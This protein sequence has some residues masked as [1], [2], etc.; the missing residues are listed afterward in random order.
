MTNNS[1]RK[2]KTSP[3]ITL[4]INDLNL[5]TKRHRVDDWMDK[6]DPAIHCHQ[7]THKTRKDIQNMSWIQNKVG[8]KVTRQREAENELE[9]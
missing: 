8:N 5:P 7:E 2:T 6:Q 4:H 3:I 1:P 9:W